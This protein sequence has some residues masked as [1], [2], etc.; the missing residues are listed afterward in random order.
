MLF[1]IEHRGII[2]SIES[3]YTSSSFIDYVFSHLF[4]HFTILIEPR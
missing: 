1:Q 3:D 4:L 2:V